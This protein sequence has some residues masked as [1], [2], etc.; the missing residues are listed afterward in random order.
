MSPKI[1][2]PASLTQVSK[3]PNRAMAAAAM[4]FTSASTPTSATT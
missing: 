4:A 1:D 3:P 2:T